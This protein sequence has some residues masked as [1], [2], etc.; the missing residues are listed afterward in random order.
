MD[1]K[2]SNPSP[3]KSAPVMGSNE[4]RVDEEV[5]ELFGGG[6]G[7]AAMPTGSADDFISK[8]TRSKVAII[9]PL[10]GYWNDIKG[11]Y[12]D[13]EILAACVERARSFAHNAYIILLAEPQRLPVETVKVLNSK[14]IAGNTHGIPMPIGSSYGD[15]IR[16]GMQVALTETD[17]AFFVFINPWVVIQDHGVDTLIDRVNVPDNAPVICGYDMRGALSAEEFLKHKPN[18][19][20]EKMVLNFNF[21]GMARWIAEMAPFD[22][23]IKTQPFL[24]RDFFQTVASKGKCAVSSER[25]PIFSFDV[26]WRQYVPEEDYMTDRELFQAKWRFNP[27]DVVIEKYEK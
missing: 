17:A 4:A 14:F 11:G 12:L 8:T 6:G 5:N 25:V 23:N 9:I 22:P 24:E 26:D 7:G 16:K 21:F 27:E 1:Q 3:R 10:F 2:Q 15:Y 20:R 19:P 13:E 18:V